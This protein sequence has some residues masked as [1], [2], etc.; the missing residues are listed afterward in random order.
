M[1]QGHP[2]GKHQGGLITVTLVGAAPAS[3]AH[4]RLWHKADIGAV[5]SDVRFRGYSGHHLGVK[6]TSQIR[7]VMSAFDPM[8][9]FGGK[10]DMTRTIALTALLF[11]SSG[12]INV[13][14]LAEPPGRYIIASTTC[15]CRE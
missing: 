2:C 15:S 13:G 8:S 11:A 12:T 1:G 14:Y 3:V 4:V 6:Q 9:A 10:P 5:L 7:P